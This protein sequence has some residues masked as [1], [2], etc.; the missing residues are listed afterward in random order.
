MGANC[1][2]Y[3]TFF[4]KQLILAGSCC[5]LIPM[6]ST[7]QTI[8]TSDQP[9]V[10]VT[11]SESAGAEDLGESLRVGPS[12]EVRGEL[13][14]EVAVQPMVEVNGDRQALTRRWRV[15]THAN[16][17]AEYNDNIFIQAD[18]RVSDFILTLAPGITIG[19]W[20]DD[21]RIDH[22]LDREGSAAVIER[23]SGSFLMLDYTAILVGFAETQSQ[24][25]FDQEARIDAQWELGRAVFTAGSRF[26]QRTE[27]NADVGDRVRRTSLDTSVG[28]KYQ[29]SDKASVD[30]ALNNRV[31][32][33]KGRPGNTEWSAEGFFDF[34][35]TPLVRFGLGAAAG[36]IDV[37]EA[38]DQRF[39]RALLR[40]AYSVTGRLD[41]FARGGAEFRQS[42]E[43]NDKIH[44]VFGLGV[45]F[46]P[47]ENTRFVLEGY[48]R[49]DISI[50]DPNREITVTGAELVL[51]R[52]VWNRV[53]LSLA[54]GYEF[55]DYDD[56][57]AEG[58]RRDHQFTLRPAILYNI[59]P[60]A[61]VELS[62][63]FRRN[64]SSRGSSDFTNNIIQ[65]IVGLN[66]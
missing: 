62:Y 7:A 25:S 5:L 56:N 52:A 45:D 59:A 42:G 6:L 3:I 49:I 8:Q 9:A 1:L 23:G 21:V 35:T 50:D 12:V 20:G 22:Y 58:A 60:W 2:G 47:A 32:E 34:Q 10:P 37:E 13:D 55:A 33:Y 41:I 19:I 28:M 38:D 14:S 48:R 4:R 29:L 40:S 18:N 63:V 30:F 16:V 43:G 11:V 66:Y 26:E 53:Q 51:R 15:K 61:N 39:A 31:R 64:D 54:A 44:P 24:N 46:R 27:T 17:I 36:Y 57:S 65:I